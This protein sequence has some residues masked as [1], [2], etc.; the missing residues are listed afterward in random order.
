MKR[1]QQLTQTYI[2]TPSRDKEPCFEVKG[3]PENV[4]LAR[5]EIESYI[6]LRTGNNSIEEDST[7]YNDNPFSPSNDPFSPN[8]SSTQ[9]LTQQMN[10][11]QLSDSPTFHFPGH[12]SSPTNHSSQREVLG[13][14]DGAGRN[15]WKPPPPTVFSGLRFTPPSNTYQPTSAPLLM[16]GKF[17]DF[18]STSNKP[19]SSSPTG[20]YESNSSDGLAATSPKQFTRLLKRGLKSCI[21]CKADN[22]VAA[23]LVPCGHNMFCQTCVSCTHGSCPVCSA[24][25][26]GVVRM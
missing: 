17:F 13:S 15:Q 26:T 16:P 9:M 5:K 24:Q 23:A 11:C 7:F 8:Q 6:A 4:Q 21:V 1:I 14:Q 20:S 19:Q 12:A 18:N 25:V 22:E 2:V 10:Q 3:T